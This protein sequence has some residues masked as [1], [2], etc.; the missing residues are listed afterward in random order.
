MQFELNEASW[1]PVLFTWNMVISWWGMIYIFGLA[2]KTCWKEKLC[3]EI[4]TWSKHLECEAENFH[5]LL[6][7]QIC[8]GPTQTLQFKD[9]KSF[10]SF[11]DSN[12]VGRAQRRPLAKAWDLEELMRSLGKLLPQGHDKELESWTFLGTSSITVG[13]PRLAALDFFMAQRCVANCAFQ[14]HCYTSKCK[15]AKR[16]LIMNLFSTSFL[17]QGVHVHV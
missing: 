6:Q 9:S 4:W 3:Q 7:P 8:P 13:S 5:A 12:Q 11:Q 2:L 10:P 14:R 1:M 15:I 17:S 16:N